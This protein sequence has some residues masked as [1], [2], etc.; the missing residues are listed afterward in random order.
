MHDRIMPI[1]IIK[2]VVGLDSLEAFAQWQA[3]ERV[4]YD[5]QWA[6]IVRTR[7]MPVK[8]DEIIAS[9]GSIYRV[10]KHHIVCRQKIIGFEQAANDHRG[11]HCV[12][13]LDTDIIRTKPVF[14]RPFQGWRY[15][16][17]DAA[18]DDMGRYALGKTEALSK[19]E[20]DL[21][22]AGLL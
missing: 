11:S 15:L 19:T 13:L 17:P 4:R 14:K 5:G 6:N 7:N 20:I 2:L 8:S 21:V 16:K 3:H 1:H 22:S 18:P 12:I 9:G 10:M